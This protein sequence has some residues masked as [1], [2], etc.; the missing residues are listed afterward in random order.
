M[1]IE[2]TKLDELAPEK[3][4]AMFTTLSQLLQERHPEV[5]LTRGVFHDLV[6]YF[7]SVLGAALQENIDRVLQSNSLQRINNNPALADPEIVDQVLSNYNLTRD[8][9]TRATGLVTI[10]SPLDS[11]V[12]LSA[13]VNLTTDSGIVFNP[14]TAIRILPT[15]GVITN[16]NDRKM[17][18]VG[19][20]TFVATIPVIARTVGTIGNVRRNTPL[21]PDFMPANVSAVYATADFVDGRNPATNADYISRLAPALAAKTIGGRQSYIAAIRSQQPFDLIPH[22]SII[23]AGDPEQ[24]RDQHGLFPVSG[25]GKVDIYLQSHNHA[26]TREYFLEA[27]FVGP[28]TIGSRWKITFDRELVPGLYE[29][30]RVAKPTDQTSSGYEIITDLRGVDLSDLDFVPS[31][32]YLYEGAYTR[33]QTVQIVFEDT[34]TSILNLVPAQSKAIYSV[35]TSSLPY[36]SDVQDFLAD[37]D[38]RSRTAD[39]LVRAAIPCFT[40]I[41]F[42]IKKDAA[43]PDPDVAAIKKAVSEKIA[44]VGF[45]G[46]LHAS[47]ITAAAQQLLTG[48]QALGPIDMFGRIR[49]PDGQNTY[50]RDNT[51]L[52]IPNNPQQLITGRTTAFLTRPE[53]IA[54]TTVVANFAG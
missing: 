6:L 30:L 33:Y 40:T 25:G 3:I 7:S 39:I 4:E 2:I 13:N 27:T 51:V 17:S 52:R 14:T 50:I 45:T 37:R 49:R 26:Q 28:G 29:V 11:I 20:G 23:G 15:T 5:E 32:K 12:N 35:V 34:D 48:K 46:Q 41:S 42:E 36:I 8:A 43:D 44:A 24:Q 1:A 9:G 16:D 19:D 47:Q 54:I 18:R 21:R 10:V 31:I 22:I 38:R 53:D